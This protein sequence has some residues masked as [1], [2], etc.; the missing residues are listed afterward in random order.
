MSPTLRLV[1]LFAA[2]VVMGAG[3]RVIRRKAP[4]ALTW[5]FAAWLMIWV[6]LVWRSFASGEQSIRSALIGVGIS[7]VVSISFLFIPAIIAN[8]R[9]RFRDR[10][11]ELAELNRVNVQL[12][13]LCKRQKKGRVDF[14]ITELHITCKSCRRLQRARALCLARATLVFLTTQLEERRNAGKDAST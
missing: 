12:F 9:D 5:W 6:V 14:E 13:D 10:R 2:L 3:E 1:L 4:R 11:E 8:I 7:L